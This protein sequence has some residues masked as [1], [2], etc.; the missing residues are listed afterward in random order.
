VLRRQ[1]EPMEE[2]LCAGLRVKVR[3]T[4]G[5]RGDT[6]V[7]LAAHWRRHYQSAAM[8]ESLLWEQREQ[9]EVRERHVSSHRAAE[10]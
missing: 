6:G 1:S 8:C 4:V 2:T 5:G 7:A 9:S 10:K 3:S